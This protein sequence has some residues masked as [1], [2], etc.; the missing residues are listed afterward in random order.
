MAVS[1]QRPSHGLHRKKSLVRP[2]RNRI[3]KDHPN[4]HYRKHAQNM[5]VLPSSTGND[6]MVE[7]HLEAETLS[8]EET[9]IKSF[10]HPESAVTESPLQGRARRGRSATVET[11]HTIGGRKLQKT[12][13]RK[14]TRALEAEEKRRQKE[15][16][17]A[18]TPNLWSVYCHLVTFWCPDAILRCF[19]KPQKAQQRAWREKMGLISIILLI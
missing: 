7:D 8:S 16:D 11:A 17:D 13:S 12:L 2:E 19:G 4:Y 15:K 3:D 5:T 6:P 9:D 1:T 10:M 14:D 18:M